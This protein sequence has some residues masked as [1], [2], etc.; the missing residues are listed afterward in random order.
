MVN[1]PCLE[2]MFDSSLTRVPP[3]ARKRSAASG[4]LGGG[5]DR[6]TRPSR[7]KILEGR[8]FRIYNFKI[9]LA[10]TKISRFSTFSKQCGE[11]RGEIRILGLVVLTHR[12]E[13]VPLPLSKLR[14]NILGVY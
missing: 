8:P 5:G 12:N 14:G 2:N 3:L 10:H 7:F 6:E 11:I 4:R 9:F 1:S 13:S